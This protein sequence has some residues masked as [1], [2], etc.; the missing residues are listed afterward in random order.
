MLSRSLFPRGQ[1][2]Y[3]LRAFSDTRKGMW[4][5]K[6]KLANLRLSKEVYKGSHARTHARTLTEVRLFQLHF[7]EFLKKGN[8]YRSGCF[9][10]TQPRI[11]ISG[12]T[13]ILLTKRSF[14]F[15]STLRTRT[16]LLL[17]AKTLKHNNRQEKTKGILLSTNY[18]PNNTIENTTVL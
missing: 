1:S 8:K 18:P 11:Y 3:L 7:S 2:E 9:R 14:N 6:E 13:P 4:K 15:L 5:G 10:F 16:P 17:T 12:F